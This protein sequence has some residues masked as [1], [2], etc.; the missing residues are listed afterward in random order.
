MQ[1]RKEGPILNL[2]ILMPV[3]RGMSKRQKSSMFNRNSEN[4]IDV[5][6]GL[7]S[8]VIV[9]NGN[10]YSTEEECVMRAMIFAGGATMIT[11]FI[12]FIE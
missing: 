6:Q 8:E 7:M 11:D 10:E 2:H 9:R 1:L 4:S 3:L 5:G 12:H